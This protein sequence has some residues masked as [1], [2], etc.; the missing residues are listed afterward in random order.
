ML[1]MSG[2]DDKMMPFA[3]GD[4]PQA[5]GQR[6]GAGLGG[7]IISAP[8]TVQFWARVNGCGNEKVQELPDKADDGTQVVLHQFGC[9]SGQVVFYEIRG[10]GHNWAGGPSPRRPRLQQPH[11]QCQ[12]GHQRDV[13]DPQ[14]LQAIRP[15]KPRHHAPGE[16]CESGRGASHVSKSGCAAPPR[17]AVGDTPEEHRCFG[18]AL[19]PYRCPAT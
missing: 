2:T 3:G 8:E 7:R 5:A 18:R 6:N 15:L 1:L 9:G 11:R 13:R 16:T 17:H 19:P 4:L 12:Q 14:L 10:G